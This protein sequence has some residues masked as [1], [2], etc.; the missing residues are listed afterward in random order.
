[1]GGD[2]RRS[3]WDQNSS[4]WSEHYDTRYDEDYEDVD[5]MESDFIFLGMVGIIDPPRSEVYDAIQKCQDAGIRVKM[6]TG[7][8]QMTAQAIGEELDIT[9]PHIEAVSGSRLLELD[10]EAMRHTAQNTSI[11]SRV[12][13]DQKML[14][15]TAL[16]DDGEVVAMTGDG[17]NDAPA[18]SR[19]NIGISM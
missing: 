4:W 2:D 13:P 18:L 14:I 1:M 11:F 19:A 15:V 7:D 12:S 3:L 10:D 8:Q 9:N 6:I 16:Q 5:S 17:V